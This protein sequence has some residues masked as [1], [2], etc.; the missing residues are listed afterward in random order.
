MTN[1]ADCT[2]D[3]KQSSFCSCSLTDL[4]FCCLIQAPV[5]AFNTDLYVPDQP[6]RDCHPAG[7]VAYNIHAELFFRTRYVLNSLVSR[8][9]QQRLQML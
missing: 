9:A 4:E 7:V 6:D 1:T 5:S 8:E 3:T 2:V